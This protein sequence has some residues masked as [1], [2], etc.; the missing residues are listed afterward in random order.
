M[1]D[2]PVLNPAA[3]ADVAP[4][5]SKKWL[6]I[7]IAAFVVLAGGGAAT[8]MLIDRKSVV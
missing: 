6:I 2:V 7:G 4:Q 5:K 1:A 3:D 8:F